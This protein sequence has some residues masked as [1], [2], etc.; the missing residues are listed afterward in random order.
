MAG[1]AEDCGVPPSEVWSGSVDLLDLD[2]RSVVL[3]REH[4]H[5]AALDEFLTTLEGVHISDDVEPV[6]VADLS[7]PGSLLTGRRTKQR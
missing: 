5:E 7:P 4:E 6:T 1:V 2:E 3:A